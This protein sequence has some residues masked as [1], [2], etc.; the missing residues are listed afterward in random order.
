M[1]D[2]HF[3]VF[4]DV[5]M[6]TLVLLTVIEVP[7]VIGFSLNDSFGLSLMDNIVDCMFAFDMVRIVRTSSFL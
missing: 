6:V 1:A 4:M 5:V 7:I 2:D 3:R